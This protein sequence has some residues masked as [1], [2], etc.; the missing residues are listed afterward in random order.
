MRIPAGVEHGDRLRLRG[1]GHSSRSGGQPGDLFLDIV[2]KKHPFF[3]REGDD[4]L[5][6]VSITRREARVGATV[7]IPTLISGPISFKIPPRTPSG[8]A[9][10]LKGKGIPSPEGKGRGDQKITIRVT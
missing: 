9:F 6:E 1:Q 7:E 4:L 3:R 8:K 2:V 5:C 10:T